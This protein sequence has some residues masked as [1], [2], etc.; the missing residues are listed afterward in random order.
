METLL[1]GLAS[2]ILFHFISRPKSKLHKKLPKARIVK[3]F[4]L[5]PRVTFEAKNR[6]FHFHHWMV[7]AP[8]YIF[9]QTIG[10]DLGILQ[11]DLIQGFMLGG[12][13]QGLMYDDSFKFVHRNHEYDARVTSSSYHGFRFLKKLF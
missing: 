6:I 2:F 1:S 3:R 9:S 5:F 13:I 10:K 11:S 4:E 7:L 8:I 12:I